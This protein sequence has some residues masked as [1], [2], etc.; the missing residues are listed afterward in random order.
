MDFKLKIVWKV[1]V[2]ARIEVLSKNLC[3]LTEENHKNTCSQDSWSSGAASVPE[4]P[5]IWKIRAND[6]VRDV[7]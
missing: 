5:R 4:T 3:V 6:L 2:L 7:R 1:M